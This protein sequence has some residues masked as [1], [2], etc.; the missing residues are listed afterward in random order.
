MV[1]DRAAPGRFLE[2]AYAPGDHLAILVKSSAAGG[3]MQRIV[4]RD[5]A[6]APRFQAW[7]RAC[8]AQRWNVYVSVNAVV[9]G[10]SRTRDAIAAVRHVFLD[11]D[12]DVD[13]VLARI[14]IESRLP[15]PSYQL[16]SSPGKRH[17]FWRVRGMS[18]GD[19]ER[20]QKHLA[21]TLGTDTAATSCAQLTR[22]PGFVNHKYATRPRVT[23]EYVDATTVLDAASFAHVVERAA[24][25]RVTDPPRP[26]RSPRRGE[27]TPVRRA[28]GFLRDLPPAIQGQRGDLQ[29]FRVCCRLVRGFALPDEDA[30]PL[31][32]EWNARCEPP[33]SDEDLAAKLRAARRYGKET[34]GRLL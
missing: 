22:L 14:A 2:T 23:I 29:T 28:R 27:A 31:L 5:A 11:A 16:Q 9:A 33:W 21:R 32:R 26:S 20:V 13:A 24:K 18:S 10:R 30:W 3:V 6:C 1:I 17:V 8:N 4:S 19:V 15:P 25:D 34:M 12:H 7:L